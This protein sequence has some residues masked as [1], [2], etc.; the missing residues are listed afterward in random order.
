L[1]A[2][3]LNAG[4]YLESMEYFGVGMT[5]S[6]FSNKGSDQIGFISKERMDYFHSDHPKITKFA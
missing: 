1:N 4:K 5:L 3:T 2:I 6:R